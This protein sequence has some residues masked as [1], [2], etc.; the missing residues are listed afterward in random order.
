MLNKRPAMHMILKVH[1]AMQSLCI[2]IFILTQHYFNL[3]VQ[4]H[5]CQVQRRTD[6]KLLTDLST[7]SSE[8]IRFGVKCLI[9]TEDNFCSSYANIT[10]Q[11][12]II[13]LQSPG[14]S[15]S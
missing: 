3:I 13:V 8:V 11:T 1:N 6:I 15:N 5:T 7:D 4:V 10:P 9:L 2:T 14:Q 12:L